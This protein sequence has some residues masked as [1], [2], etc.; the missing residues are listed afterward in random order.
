MICLYCICLCWSVFFVSV[1]VCVCCLPLSA[2]MSQSVCICVCLFL[3][4]SVCVCPSLSVC[5]RPYSPTATR[6]CYVSFQFMYFVVFD[7]PFNVFLSVS[8]RL[9]RHGG[10]PSTPLDAHQK[11]SISPVNFRFIY[12]TESELRFQTFENIIDMWIFRSLLNH[13]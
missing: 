12:G 3:P 7:N 6:F 11:V 4:V 8:R 9:P 13:Y 2:C 1:F 5:V 10:L